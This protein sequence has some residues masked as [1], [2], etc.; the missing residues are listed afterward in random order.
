[1]RSPLDKNAT[2]GQKLNFIFEH[3]CNHKRAEGKKTN[4]EGGAII[5]FA[6]SYMNYQFDYFGLNS[7]REMAFYLDTLENEEF[8]QFNKQSGET[9]EHLGERTGYYK[10]GKITFKGLS[11]LSEIENK[12]ILS[13]KCFVAMAFDTYKEERIAAIKSACSEHGFDAFIVEEYKTKEN[14][15]IDTNIIAAIKSARFCIADFTGINRG[16]YFEAGY[17]MGR[18]MKVIFVC[19]ETDFQEN[20]KHFDVN[21]YP[22][23]PYK[24][25]QDLTSK[26]KTEITA[27]I[28][29]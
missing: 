5:D 16:A 2:P 28:K 4:K 23:I 7:Y 1:M 12:G 22:F 13:N 26:L 6:T 18:N 19:E 8:I 20:K 15:T 9:K 10:L 17:A 14:Q 25:F 11:Y 24:N 29:D 3:I 27:Y 21:H